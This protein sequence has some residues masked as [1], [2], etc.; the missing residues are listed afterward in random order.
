MYLFYF[1]TL[2]W[3]C[4]TL[5]WICHGCTCV[6]HPEAPLPTPSPSHPSGS[7][8]CTSPEHPA[9]CMEPGLVICFTYDNLH[10][11]MSFSH[12][13]PP[14]PSPTESNEFA[15]H[16]CAGAMLIFSVSFQLEYMCCWSE[17][18]T[19]FKNWFPI[20]YAQEFSSSFT[21]Q[22]LGCPCTY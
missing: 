8:Q 9:S 16:P 22:N 18:W 17:H 15:C 13:I 21:G 10:V 1:T 7:S 5:T 12:I 6:P 3:F 2:Y 11:S 14:L 20:H 19:L 4:H